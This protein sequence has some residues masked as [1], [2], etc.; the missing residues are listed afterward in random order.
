M[1]LSGIVNLC[2]GFLLLLSII[3]VWSRWRRGGS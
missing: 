1:T 2:C 3:W